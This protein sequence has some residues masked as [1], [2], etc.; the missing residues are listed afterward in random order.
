MSRVLSPAAVHLDV[1]WRLWDVPVLHA[2]VDGAVCPTLS[3]GRT[4]QRVSAVEAGTLQASDG[5]M[6]CTTC[7]PAA[8][9]S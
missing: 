9:A 4:T 1:E 8:R 7:I 2:S 3:E 5:A 6:L